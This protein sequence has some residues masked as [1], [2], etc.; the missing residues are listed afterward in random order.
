MPYRS[1]RASP[2]PLSHN[3]LPQYLSTAH[4]LVPLSAYP[5]SVPHASPRYRASHREPG[6]CTASAEDDT[7]ARYIN[8]G[9]C[10]AGAQAE[11]E[12]VRRGEGEGEEGEGEAAKEGESDAG[13]VG[14]WSRG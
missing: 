6:D 7:S 4:R 2:D 1:N 14:G 9:N 3:T 8:A 10:I 13:G 11:D 12:A 5:M